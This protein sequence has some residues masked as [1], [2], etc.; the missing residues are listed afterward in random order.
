MASYCE[1]LLMIRMILESNTSINNCTSITLDKMMEM[2]TFCIQT[3]FFNYG[4][5]YTSTKK[6]RLF[7]TF[8]NNGD[9]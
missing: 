9:L 8:I 1:T 7:V 2:F 5:I 6:G 3:P 4:L